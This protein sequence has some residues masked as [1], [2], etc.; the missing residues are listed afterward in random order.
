MSS[1]SNLEGPTPLVVGANSGWSFDPNSHIRFV[2][3]S[4]G[5]TN[6]VQS[7]P[8][9]SPSPPLG[10]P[11]IPRAGQLFPPGAQSKPAVPQ[12]SA[13]P[14]AQGVR[15]LAGR[16]RSCPPIVHCHSFRLANN[17]PPSTRPSSQASILGSPDSAKAWVPTPMN[18]YEVLHEIMR[19][20]YSQGWPQPL[21]YVVFTEA[22]GP[23]V[24]PRAS[25]KGHVHGP[26]PRL[27]PPTIAPNAHEFAVQGVMEIAATKVKK[28]GV[29]SWVWRH[30]L[31]QDAS[32]DIPIIKRVRRDLT[33]D[34]TGEDESEIIPLRGNWLD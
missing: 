15:W 20:T 7:I 30:I 6:A 14:V 19:D 24:V 22:E 21:Q 34:L 3:I 9:G 1:D 29:Y 23:T 5:V 8:L 16:K 32:M 26:S 25:M 27:L 4:G 18:E 13:S 11:C 17:W 31:G 33:L 2:P 10:L 28:P 12:S